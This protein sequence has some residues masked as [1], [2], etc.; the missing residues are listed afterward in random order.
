MVL[1]IPCPFWWF[2]KCKLQLWECDIFSFF[3]NQYFELVIYQWIFGKIC[4]AEKAVNFRAYI[5]FF[6][7][8]LSRGS[9]MLWCIDGILLSSKIY[10]AT[11]RPKCI[12]YLL[13]ENGPWETGFG[14]ALCKEWWERGTQEGYLICFAGGLRGSTI[15]YFTL[16]ITELLEV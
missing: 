7:C 15:C 14:T 4:L 8:F 12:H 9:P 5:L 2:T 1:F 6:F 16:N 11:L 13:V 3:V 10:R